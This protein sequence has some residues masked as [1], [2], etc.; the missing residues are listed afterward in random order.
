MAPTS[1]R[2]TTTNDWVEGA[3]GGTPGFHP[4]MVPLSVT[5]MN[6][7]GPESTPSLTMKLGPP[8]KTMPVG[9]PA[10]WT[11]SGCGS[12]SPL[13]SVE[14]LVSLSATHQKVVGPATRHQALTRLGSV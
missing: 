11:T 14:T 10:T 9:A 13:Y 5:H 6:L 4:R 3:G 2:S 7:D 8:L 1:E 12:P